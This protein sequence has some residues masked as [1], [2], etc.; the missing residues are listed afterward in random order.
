MNFC[1]SSGNFRHQ[2]RFRRMVIVFLCVVVFVSAQI[3][4]TQPAVRSRTPQQTKEEG[5]QVFESVCAG[6]HGLDGRGGERGPDIATRQQ[7]VQLSDAELLE[8]LRSGRPASGMPPFDSLG[9]S[10]LKALLGYVRSLQGKGAVAASPG[11]PR[12]GKVLFFGKA[13]CSECH[14]LQGVGGFL[15]RDLTTYGATLSPA[16]IRAN[17]LKAGDSADKAN[18]TAVITMRNSQKF[19][20][21]IRN[22]D[23]FSIQLQSRDGTFHFLT[24]SSV[25]HLEFLSDPIMPADY[26]MLLKPNELDDLVSYLLTVART[27]K[28]RTE[29]DGEDDN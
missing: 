1:N 27:G 23:N 25:L 9:N 14:M 21:I 20:G 19:T 12:T 26:G 28:T 2:F 13:R 15:G 7:V 11:D 3:T 4:L 16:E 24:R 5:H 29:V 6:C 8:I 17:V 10:R 22:E 18:K